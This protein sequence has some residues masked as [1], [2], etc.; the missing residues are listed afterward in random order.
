MLLPANEQRLAVEIFVEGRAV[1]A[2]EGDTL[3]AALLNAGVV[4]FRHTPVSGQP[5][6]PLC[7]MGVCFD[8]LVEVN[9]AQN[10]QSCMV[11]VRAGMQVR[12]PNGARTAGVLK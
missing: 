8:C 10:V 2:R 7:L 9:G 3:A 1:S 5:R 11:Q 6:A 12:L 4:P